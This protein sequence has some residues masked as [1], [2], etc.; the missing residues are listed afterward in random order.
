LILYLKLS[1]CRHPSSDKAI[2]YSSSFV[3]NR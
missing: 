1:C 3:K 2:R